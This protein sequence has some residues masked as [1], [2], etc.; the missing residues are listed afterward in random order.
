M[1]LGVC[2]IAIG[3]FF[4]SRTLLAPHAGPEQSVT[5][6]MTALPSGLPNIAAPSYLPPKK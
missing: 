6:V 2:L 4:W 1:I 3:L 5:P